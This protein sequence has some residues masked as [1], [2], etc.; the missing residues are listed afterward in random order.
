[1]KAQRGCRLGLAVLSIATPSAAS[2]QSRAAVEQER[3]E[4]TVWLSTAPLSPRRAV[5]VR[6]IGPGL[7]LGPASA[8]I[9]L[10]GAD[11]ARVTD[12]GRVMLRLRD[13]NLSLARGRPVSMG[14]WRLLVNGP[15]GRAAITVFAKDVRAGKAPAWYPYDPKAVSAVT[16]VPPPAPGTVRILGPDGVDVDAS[17]AGTVEVTF[18]GSRQTLRVLRLPGA[19]ED[20]SEL[21]I[22]FRDGTSGHGT[23]PAGR[24]VSLIP[25]AGGYLLDFN[26]ARNPYC[27]YN[28]VFPCPAPWRGNA[29]ATPIRA[30]ERY[31]GG[32]LDSPA[33]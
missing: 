12:D 30:G 28:T 21:E 14:N 5:L 4:F 7:S 9:P 27:A 32:G 1:M 29:I 25:R 10:Q 15:P 33:Y 13:Q 18:G 3:R 20:E 24:F 22:Y 17:E 11:P 19:T 23:Y 2:A 16:L 6:P 8:D 26:R 31:L